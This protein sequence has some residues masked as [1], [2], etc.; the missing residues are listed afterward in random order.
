MSVLHVVRGSSPQDST[1]KC[2]LVALHAALE[3]TGTTCACA[4][5]NQHHKKSWEQ[6]RKEAQKDMFAGRGYAFL[7]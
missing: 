3:H 7:C 5:L 4:S 1:W 6:P 2:L